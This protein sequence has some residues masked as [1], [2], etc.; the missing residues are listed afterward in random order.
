MGRQWSE[1]KHGR[2][3]KS[4]RGSRCR[5]RGQFRT[6]LPIP[7]SKCAAGRTY[8]QENCGPISRYCINR[9]CLDIKKLRKLALKQTQTWKQTEGQAIRLLAEMFVHSQMVSTIRVRVSFIECSG[10]LLASPPLEVSL[11]HSGCAVAD[12]SPSLCWGSS[13]KLV[14]FARS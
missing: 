6:E 13:W 12:E 14:C 4:K 9:S 5:H 11:T 8:R 3:K 10:Q 1:L 2:K 7:S